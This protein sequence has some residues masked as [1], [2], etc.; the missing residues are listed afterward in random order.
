LK[1]VAEIWKERIKRIFSGIIYNSKAIYNKFGENTIMPPKK[2]VS[3]KKIG[4]TAS[5]NI[6]RKILKTSEDEWK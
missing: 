1:G 2:N 5:A 3:S 4:S 6:A